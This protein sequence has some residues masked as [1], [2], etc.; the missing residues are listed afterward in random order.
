[1]DNKELLRH[2]DRPI[3]FHRIFVDWT[4]S[5]NAALMLSQ[6]VYWS[7]RTNSESGWV[8]KTATEWQEETGLSRREQ[9]FAR[10]ALRERKLVEEVVCGIPAKLHFRLADRFYQLCSGETSFNET[11]KLDAT[12]RRNRLQRGVETITETTHRIQQT[13]GRKG[14]PTG[15]TFFKDGEVDPF[16]K[17]ACHKLEDWLRATRRLNKSRFNP[18]KWYEDMRLLLKDLDGDKERLKRVLQIYTT[19]EHTKYTPKVESAQT[20][21]HKFTRI[22]DWVNEQR[23]ASDEP[24]ITVIEEKFDPKKHKPYDDDEEF[25]ANVRRKRQ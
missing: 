11:L 20:F 9:E 2:F 8:F 3:A 15:P 14:P 4:E 23:P 12:K 10:K 24:K 22:E 18:A 5:V 21:R 16:V 6:L 19:E 17:T 1:M 25:Y 7:Q 13:G